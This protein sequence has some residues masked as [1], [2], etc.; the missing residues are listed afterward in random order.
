VPVI[1]PELALL[2]PD[3]QEG[4]LYQLVARQLVKSFN[5]DRKDLSDDYSLQDVARVYLQDPAT[6][7]KNCTMKFGNSSRI[8]RIPRRSP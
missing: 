2:K 1:G 7:P 8:I 5:I 4:T 6:G 3:E